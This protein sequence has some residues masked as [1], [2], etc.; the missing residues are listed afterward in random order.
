MTTVFVDYAG[1]DQIAAMRVGGMSILE[2]V[3][4]VAALAGATRARVRL[5][6]DARPPL[7]PLAIEVEYVDAPDRTAAI[8][9]GDVVAGVEVVDGRSRRRAERALLQSCRRPY[10]GLGDTYV[11]RPV[12]LR[13]TPLLARLGAT[14]NQVTVANTVWGALACALVVIGGRGPIAAGGVAIFLQAVFD[15]CDGELARIRYLYSNFGR[16]LDNASDDVIDIGMTLALGWAL[17]GWWWPVAVVAGVARAS[18]ALM[19]F[20]AVARMGKPGDVLAFR[21]FFDRAESELTDRFEH[22]LTPLAVVRSLGRR[23]AYVL[24]WTA[25]CLAGVLEPGLVLGLIVAFGYFGLSLVHRVVRARTPAAE[26]V[27]M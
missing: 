14:P 3:V 22:K 26:R 25:S 18:C 5:R 20:R 7:P 8:V 21:W 6:A 2:R 16:M 13:L 11:I 27:G 19:I 15:S 12:S 4:R 23:D 9:P 24:V 1:R 10:D 17:G